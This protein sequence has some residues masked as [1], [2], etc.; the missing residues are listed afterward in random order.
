MISSNTDTK[1]IS[2]SQIKTYLSCGRKYKY[3]YVEGIKPEKVSFAM[4]F[5]RAFHQTVADIN[6]YRKKH[7]SLEKVDV[8]SLFKETFEREIDTS[9][10][11]VEFDKDED[12]LLLV[13]YADKMLKLYMEHI[14]QMNTEVIAIEH[15]ISYPI[16]GTD[17]VF[18]GIVD[19]IEKDVSGIC[20]VELKTAEKM[21]SDSTVDYDLQGPLYKKAIT[22]VYPDTPIKVRYDIVTRGK[23]PKVQ[24]KYSDTNNHIQLTDILREVIYGI[25]KNVYTP[26]PGY[27][28][29]SCDYK[30]ICMGATP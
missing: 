29:T 8:S 26:R 23:S 14:G 25:E 5:G 12:P 6:L 4:P 15:E 1:H 9:E 19:A 21:W 24:S 3:K 16:Q 30:D 17:Y 13:S 18:T 27:M 28:C 20:I 2:P 11:P 22:P 10:T 7:Q